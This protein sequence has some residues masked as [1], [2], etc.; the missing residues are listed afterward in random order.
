MHAALFP[1]HT[2]EQ[3]LCLFMLQQFPSREGQTAARSV[4]TF[5]LI[6]P[7]FTK[8]QTEAMRFHGG[9]DLYI[10][11]PYNNFSPLMNNN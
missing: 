2:L 1:S 9:N 6:L 5:R 3:S 4:I 8:S 10:V 11:S 7:K